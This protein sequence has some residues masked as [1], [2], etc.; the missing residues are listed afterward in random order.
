MFVHE[1]NMLLNFHVHVITIS[2]LGASV[3]TNVNFPIC[4]L[5]CWTSNTD[6]PLTN[7]FLL[8]DEYMIP[9]FPEYC[10]CVFG[11]GSITESE[12][13][14]SNSKRKAVVQW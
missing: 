14:K 10:R 13:V 1:Y 7:F 2:F 12:I 4:I 9:C 3:V 5:Y 6:S 11:Y 8:I